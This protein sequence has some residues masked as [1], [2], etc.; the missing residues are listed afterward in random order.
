MS[1]FIKDKNTF[2][3]DFWIKHLGDFNFKFV[4][5]EQWCKM[6]DEE[7]EGFE[8]CWIEFKPL[9]WRLHNELR[10]RAIYDNPETGLKDWSQPTYVQEKMK[11]VVKDW[12]FTETD[13]DGNKIKVKVS[14][15]ALASLH[16]G[17]AEVIMDTYE[18]HT[19]LTDDKKKGL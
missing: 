17:I 8:H 3:L 7:R 5:K 16:P 12:S 4:N 1:V 9:T 15:A 14:D 18:A 10:E 19:E 11:E 2:R 6:T 13:E